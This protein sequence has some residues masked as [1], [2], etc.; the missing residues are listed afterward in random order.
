M[1]VFCLGE[2]SI[3]FGG[4]NFERT[5]SGH[6]INKNGQ[7]LSNEAM[8]ALLNGYAENGKVGCFGK[9]FGSTYSKKHL[10]MV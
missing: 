7:Q 8:N 4:V 3:R 6:Y 2:A 9:C 10:H 5:E 1:F